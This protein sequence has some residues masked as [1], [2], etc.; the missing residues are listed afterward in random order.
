MAGSLFIPTF[1]T[2]LGQALLASREVSVFVDNE[3][4]FKYLFFGK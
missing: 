1:I 3:E 4:N 2:R